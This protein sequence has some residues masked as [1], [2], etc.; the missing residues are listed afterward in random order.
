MSMQ[1]AAISE[2]INKHLQGNWKWKG[3]LKRLEVE[4]I[5]AGFVTN[6]FHLKS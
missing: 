2:T 5:E 4:F 1:S 6:A 3:F